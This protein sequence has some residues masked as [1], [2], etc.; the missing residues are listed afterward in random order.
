MTELGLLWMLLPV[1]AASGWY[2]HKRSA[3]RVDVDRLNQFSSTYFR[4]LNYLLNEEQDKAIEVFLKIAELDNNAAETQLALGSLFRRRGEVDRAIRLHQ[5][6]VSSTGL[7]AQQ[8]TQALLEL[9]EDFMRAGLLD[10]AERLF[11]ELIEIQAHT[12]S[13]LRHLISIYQQEKDWDK[14][15]EHA[16]R[17]AAVSGEDMSPVIAQFYCE[18]AQV[19]LDNDRLDGASAHTRRALKTDP[20][21]VR[22][23]M[24]EGHMAS[25][26]GDYD[27]AITA[28][29]RVEQQDLEFIPDILD[30]IFY[31][32]DKAGRKADG[33]LFLSKINERYQGIS[34]I[35][36]MAEFIQIDQGRQPAATYIGDQLRQRPSVRGLGYLIGINLIDSTGDARETL[37]IL[38]DLTSKLLEGKPVYRC[39]NC[40]FGIRT[41]HWQCPGCKHWNSVK[42]IHG[43]SGE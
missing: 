15:I 26:Q 4:G 16:R 31:C 7:D 17:L 34:P 42:P 28:F 19:A 10:R 36:A 33:M 18:L 22:A 12:P 11:S 39:N 20:N 30:S 29:S 3:D 9:G 37:L 27:A 41:L 23:S 5:G 14:S 40:G 6:L 1:A 13:A 24:I 25:M 43:V 32:F 21:C 8:R 2:L 35:I 38:R